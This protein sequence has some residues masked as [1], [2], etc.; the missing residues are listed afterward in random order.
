ML[1]KAQ[2]ESCSR[3]SCETK[4]GV[5]IHTASACLDN[6]TPS[7]LV[8]FDFEK[9]FNRIDPHLLFKKISDIGIRGFLL[10]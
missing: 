10:E 9:G 8:Q 5:M 4:L 1:S 7:E 2:E 3:Q 6:R